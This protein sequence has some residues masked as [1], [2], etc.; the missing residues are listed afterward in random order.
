MIHNPT[1]M[2]DTLDVA[3]LQQ[4]LTTQVFGRVLCVLTQTTSTNDEVKALALRGAP[5]GTVVLAEQQ[6]HGRGRQ[7]RSFASP[8][9]VGIYLSV[10]V[11]PIIDMERLPQLTLMVAVATA[12]A[13]TEVCGLSVD[14][15]WPNDVEIDG[16]K[17][18]GILTEAVIHSGELPVVII[19][20]GI[21]VNTALEQLPPALHER[22]TS[23]ALV[24]GAPV[25]RPQLIAR[26]LA[27]LEELYLAWQYAGMASILER[28]RH[29]S[30]IRDRYVRFTDA[31]GTKTGRVV[32]L[33]D[34]GALLVQTADGLQQRLVAGEVVFL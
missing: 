6:T 16:K 26:L 27:H 7:G 14:L 34:D 10:F 8:E 21:N 18:A 23:L 31:A 33:D 22:V 32:G 13:I 17:I 4:L 28:W 12:D 9:G 11:R 5:E 2:H 24:T 19:G 20:I 3:M 29:Y 30:R 1:K 25:S 15:K